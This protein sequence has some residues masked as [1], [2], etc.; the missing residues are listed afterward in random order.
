M[1]ATTSRRLTSISATPLAPPDGA[2]TLPSPAA[3]STAS[4][5]A[6]D[7]F[8][9]SPSPGSAAWLAGAPASS[10]TALA[11]E[12]GYTNGPGGAAV[13]FDS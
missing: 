10:V 4:A 2:S 5:G 9:R 7:A 13:A 11:R 1:L 3:R 12:G 6:Q 8:E